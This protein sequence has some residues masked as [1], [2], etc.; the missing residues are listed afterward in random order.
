MKLSYVIGCTILLLLIMSSCSNLLV[1]NN[2]NNEILSPEIDD[3]RTIVAYTSHSPIS[4][5]SDSD[6]ETQSWPGNGTQNNPYVISWLSITSTDVCIDIRNTRSYFTVTDC[7]ISSPPTSHNEGFYLENVTNGAVR[8][9][10]VD[11]HMEGFFLRDSKDCILT[12]NTSSDGIGIGFL[13]Y[14]SS[15]ITITNNTAIDSP[16]NGFHFGDSGNCTLTNNTAISNNCGF[17][18]YTTENCILT[19]NT[20][21]DNTQWGFCIDTHSDNSTLTHNTAINSNIG[22]AL[23]NARNCTLINN[24]ALD[25]SFAGFHIGH[26]HNNTLIE[27]TATA[28]GQGLRVYYSTGNKLY[29]NMMISNGVNGFDE[30]VIANQWDDN[31]SSGNYWDDYSGSGVVNIPGIAGSVD[32]YPFL[33]DLILPIIDSPENV[34]YAEGTKD[35]SITWTPDDAHPSNFVVYRNEIEVLSGAWNGSQ[36]IVNVDGLEAGT[37]NYTI[38]VTDLGENIARDEVVVTVLDE[39]SPMV[40]NPTDILYNESSTGNSIAWHAS[41]LHPHEYTIYVSE[42]SVR[43]GTWN[44]T[45][46]L[47][48]ISVDG[49]ETGTYNYTLE[50][51]DFAGN[52]ATDEVMVT[53]VD[54]TTSPSIDTP[55]DIEYEESTT[56]HFIIWNPSDIH[57]VHYAIYFEGSL[58]K[59]GAWNS[60]SETITISVDGLDSGTYNYTLMV[61]DIGGNTAVDSVMVSVTVATTTSTLPTTTSTLPTTNGTATLTDGTVMTI[62]V[63]SIG[64]V[65][66]IITIFIV[67]KKKSA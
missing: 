18:L 16:S 49:H 17:E 22:F 43:T 54:D 41:D 48:T 40:D 8:N 9:C 63:I 28:N 36:I 60:S 62:I 51:T 58:V 65:V 6:F 37:Y 59:S 10:I 12:N 25:N 47:F 14:T 52:R 30:G 39:T 67:L 13:F 5:T 11:Y 61:T 34:S 56:G 15:N 7:I 55:A 46:E 57:P 42:I 24:T 19:N 35:N 38:V 29:L 44:S 3:N 64:G 4:I 53:V 1:G 2:P 50:V 33:L 20:V 32:R 27:N 45:S 26:S 23:D 66:V 21:K 31:V